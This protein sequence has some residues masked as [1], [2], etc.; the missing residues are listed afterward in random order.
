MGREAQVTPGGGRNGRIGL[1][2]LGAHAYKALSFLITL[3]HEAL[4]DGEDVLGSEF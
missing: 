4:Q 1:H 2:K 3:I